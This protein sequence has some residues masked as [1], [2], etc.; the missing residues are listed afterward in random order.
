MNSVIP[1][2]LKRIPPFLRAHKTSRILEKKIFGSLYYKVYCTVVGAFI[3]FFTSQ[4]SFHPIHYK[5]CAALLHPPKT[6]LLTWNGEIRCLDC[7]CYYCWQYFCVKSLNVKQIS[8]LNRAV[9]VKSS[10]STR[11]SLQSQPY[12]ILVL[13][14]PHTESVSECFKN[15]LASNTRMSKCL[16]SCKSLVPSE[17]VW[18]QNLLYQVLTW[19]MFPIHEH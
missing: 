13:C 3:L 18:G 16:H 17:Q 15:V 1:I 9:G 19:E 5:C 4:F 10:V 11:W 7:Y 12:H 6:A 2:F 14:S 8:V